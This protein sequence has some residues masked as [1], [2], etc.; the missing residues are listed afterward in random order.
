MG[1]AGVEE[2]DGLAVHDKVAVD[3]LDGAVEAAVHGVVLGDV[4]EL[5]GG[6]V[7]GVHGDYLE[8]VADDPGAEHEA[9]DAAKPVD[10][11]FDAHFYSSISKMCSSFVCL[12]YSITFFRK[13]QYH[14]CNILNV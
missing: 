4:G 3:D 2:L 5:L 10:T 12:V 1:I 14:I 13:Y 11:N 8:V 6:L 7:R 9:A